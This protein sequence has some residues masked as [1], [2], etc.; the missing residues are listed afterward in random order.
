MI[1]V[2]AAL[3]WTATG[4]PQRA[5]TGFVLRGDRVEVVDPGSPAARAGLSPGDRLLPAGKRTWAAPSAGVLTAGLELGVPAS[6]WVER[7]GVRRWIQLIPEPPPRASRRLVAQLFMVACGFLLLASVVW[8][9]RRDP[10]TRSFVLLCLAFAMLVAPMPQWHDPRAA[11][12][13][14]AGYSGITLFLPALFIHFFALFPEGARPLGRL[15]AGVAIGYFLA[16]LLF[17]LT[18]GTLLMGAASAAAIESASGILD[19]SSAIWFAAGLLLAVALFVRSFG[20][21][22]DRDSRRRL[23]VA[24][25]GTLLG[26]TPLA[27]VTLVRNLSPVTELPGERLAVLLTLLVPASFAWAILVHR[28]FDVRVALRAAAV[29]GA[30]ALGGVVTLVAADLLE[31]SRGRA[32]ADDVTSGAL[33]VMALGGL[34]AGS[35]GELVRPRGAPLL[36]AADLAASTT[37]LAEPGAV[38]SRESLLQSTCEAL[39]EDL[40]LSG[41]AALA[42][43]ESRPRWLA[44]SGSLQ[45]SPL[46][47]RFA[48]ALS[49]G[50]GVAAIHD[51]PFEPADRDR[52]DQLAV[53]WLLPVGE[54]IRHALLLGRRLAGSWLGRHEIRELTRFTSHLGTALENLDLRREASSHVALD[55][56]LREAGAI[57]AHFLPRRAPSFPTLDCA[58]AALSSEKVGGDYYDFVENG[59]RDFTLAVGDAAGKGVPAALLLAGVQARFRSEARRGLRPSALLAAINRQL[60]QHEQPEKFVGLLC[61]HVDVRRARIG[62]ANAG[63][64]PPLVRRRDGSFEELTAG[65]VLLGVRPDAAYADAWIE[66]AAGDVVLLYTDGLTEARRGEELFGIERVRDCLA[67]FARRRASDILAALLTEVRAFAD[68]PLDDLTVVVLRQLSEPIGARARSA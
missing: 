3:V 36:P 4:L 34:L 53:G 17:A 48:L 42:L 28:L 62:F 7:S 8:A 60:L 6:W 41:C 2:T 55:R 65:G 20:A 66:L 30:L 56:E 14:E 68:R 22:R 19:A 37:G 49:A 63:L 5:Y 29:V 25:F 10:L 40:R 38:R 9:E 1:V 39:A 12:L 54:P 43:E 11:L 23:R 26:V 27:T 44:H 16:S 35:L 45:P 46:S 18:L 31:Q 13:Y 64:T 50:E 61:A 57:Q 32:F 52:L 24:L 33:V 21:T 59:D 67:A 58:A 51:L 15:G 47:E